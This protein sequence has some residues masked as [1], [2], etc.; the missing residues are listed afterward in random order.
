MKKLLLLFALGVYA[1]AATAQNLLPNPGFDQK[2]ACP[3]GTGQMSKVVNWNSYTLASPDFYNSCDATPMGFGV[4][5]NIWGVQSQQTSAPEEAYIGVF[6][7][8]PGQNPNYKEYIHAR[9]P[10]LQVGQLYEMSINVSLADDS[11]VATDGFG[12][13][14]FVAGDSFRNNSNPIYT[15]KVS[16]DSYG[17]ITNHTGWTKLTKTFIADSAYTHVVIGCFKN[18]T[19]LN[20]VV[21]TPGSDDLAYYFIDDVEL[22]LIPAGIADADMLMDGVKLYPNP[23]TGL[24]NITLPKAMRG[25]AQLAVYSMVGQKLFET[26]ITPQSSSVQLP[27]TINNGT[28]LVHIN[29]EAGAKTIPLTLQR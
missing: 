14:F 13:H 5:T 1:V 24:L 25:E 19:L 11:R 28:Y 2:T 21:I 10:A 23:S 15:P 3:T 9:I 29:T 12:V 7:Q 8:F 27:S 22:K 20:K 17:V 16:Y 6:T 26:T 18:D 4:P